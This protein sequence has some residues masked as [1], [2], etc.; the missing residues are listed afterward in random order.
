MKQKHNHFRLKPYIIGTLA[1]VAVLIAS[2][3]GVTIKRNRTEAAPT[4]RQLVSAKVQSQFTFNGV[5]D[6]RQGP[7]RLSDIALFH[8]TQDSCFTSI[9]RKTG[10]VA[11]E[12]AKREKDNASL[13]GNGYTVTPGATISVTL[14]TNAG[15]KSYQLQQFNVATP[16][17]GEKVLGGLEFGYLP[18]SETD[19]IFVEGHCETLDQLAATI[20]ALQAISFDATGSTVGN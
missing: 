5:N 2:F 4:V 3:A 8:N 1:L 7:T 13:I 15:Q 20:P 11:A 18:L 12:K 17:N 16:P 10:S 19:Y 6:W 14:P 9:Q